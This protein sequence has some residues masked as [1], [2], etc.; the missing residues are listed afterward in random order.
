MWS[1]SELRLL[2]PETDHGQCGE[3]GDRENKLDGKSNVAGTAVS[4][5]IVAG[6]GNVLEGRKQVPV[7][8]EITSARFD[9][10]CFRS[11]SM[12]D[13]SLDGNIRHNRG[14]TE[15]N[16]IDI[17]GQK[18]P[19]NQQ[20]RNFQEFELLQAYTYVTRVR[21]SMM[22]VIS[23]VTVLS[24]SVLTVGLG[25][26]GLEVLGEDGLTE[27]AREERTSKRVITSKHDDDL[28]T[29]AVQGVLSWREISR[30]P[31]FLRVSVCA[32][33]VFGVSILPVIWRG[34]EWRLAG[35]F[36]VSFVSKCCWK[37]RIE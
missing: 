31:F 10:T 6:E 36:E 3:D 28:L 11:E 9:I 20:F 35:Y 29:L 14:T 21:I 26:S 23:V 33:C 5:T 32:P 18:E 4:S 22:S 7:R 34:L 1:L 12:S 17:E 15:R 13:K 19:K 2:E 25:I 37:N 27:V 8:M 16:R 24:M 30:Q